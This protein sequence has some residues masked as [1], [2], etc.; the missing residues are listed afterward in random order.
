MIHTSC[1]VDEGVVGVQHM[2]RQEALLL[3]S[4]G[5]FLKPGEGAADRLAENR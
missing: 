1:L 2:E 4:A 5:F 3:Q